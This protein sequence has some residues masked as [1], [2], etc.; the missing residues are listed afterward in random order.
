M[1]K[2]IFNFNRFGKYFL[3]DIKTC[4]ANYGLSLI[5][6]STL[7]FLVLYVFNVG[8]NLILGNG[9]DGPD[10]GFRFFV[11]GVV[12]FCIVVTMPVKCYGKLTEKRYGSQW[13][14]IP[15]SRLEKFA[16]MIILSCIVAPVVGL[17]LYLGLDAL[18]CA[19]DPTCGDSLI[20][21]AFDIENRINEFFVAEGI[22]SEPEFPAL[23]NFLGQ[24]KS[25]WL[26]IDDGIQMLLPFL[27]G[28]LF[29]K[30]GKTVKTFL[31]IAAVSTLVSVISAPIMV[32]WTRTMMELNVDGNNIL[33]ADAL[34]GSWF[35]RNIALVDTISDTVCNVA[36][37]TA[38][39]FRIK[40]LKH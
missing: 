17:L 31:S 29:F 22:V 13:L 30:S 19:V 9:W 26:Y 35:F 15:A 25:P 27:L 7:S 6:L 4:I 2:D 18:F 23:M 40:T 3:S 12:M 37:L 1:K 34:F 5:T 11:F 28:A 24:L 38:I 36:L 20:R 10:A 39:Y 32:D 16:S 33:Y 21:W 8:L 14:M